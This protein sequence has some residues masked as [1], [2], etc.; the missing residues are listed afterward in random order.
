MGLPGG[1]ERLL[2]PEVEVYGAAAE[3]ATAPD[4]QLGRL[5]HP[6]ESQQQTVEAL[7]HGFGLAARRHGKLHV[8]DADERGTNLIV[9]PWRHARIMAP[10]RQG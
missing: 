4:S 2:D 8:I 6:Y 3:P 5:G 7:G 1:V 10:S 9:P